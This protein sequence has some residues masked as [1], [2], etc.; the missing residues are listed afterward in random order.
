M[1]GGGFGGCTITMVEANK[2][3]KIM[4]EMKR[5][6]K[7]KTGIDCD[8][9]A[10]TPC[11]GAHVVSKNENKKKSCTCGSKSC[12]CSKNS[13]VSNSSSNSCCICSGLKNCISNHPYMWGFG[14]L[15]VIG[16]VAYAVA[17]KKR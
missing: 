12:S 14:V 15:A 13:N 5:Q 1:T 17:Q 9:F 3:D 8:I 10:T 16:G 2:K 6:Y 7:V 4:E 11:E